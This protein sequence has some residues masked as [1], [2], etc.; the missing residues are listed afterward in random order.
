MNNDKHQSHILNLKSLSILNL[1][2]AL[3]TSIWISTGYAH[4]A[5]PITNYLMSMGLT[6]FIICKVLFVNFCI[7]LLWKFS[8]IELSRMLVWP[9]MF[10]YVGVTCIHV[11][12][13]LSFCIQGP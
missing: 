13:L 5:N 3:F 4:E 1:L 9:L 10:A 7:F 2:D 6:T 8:E 12:F 11:L